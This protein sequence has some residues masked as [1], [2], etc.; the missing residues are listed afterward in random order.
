MDYHQK[1]DEYRHVDGGVDNRIDEIDEPRAT[2]PF[3]EP[4]TGPYQLLHEYLIQPHP[5][6]LVAKLDEV[7]V[8]IHHTAIR[9][10]DRSVGLG[11]HRSVV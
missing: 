11:H 9:N 2:F 5:Q 1:I 6:Q 7:V 8:G 4:P 3:T 10:P